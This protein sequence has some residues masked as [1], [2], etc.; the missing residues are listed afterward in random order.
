MY[1]DMKSWSDEA[2]PG[3]STAVWD[4]VRA[5]AAHRMMQSGETR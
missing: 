3:F 4:F 5:A 1:D 2:D